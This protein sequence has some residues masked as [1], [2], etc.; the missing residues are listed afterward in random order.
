MICKLDS[1][2]KEKEKEKE[3][4]INYVICKFYLILCKSMEKITRF[5]LTMWYV[6]S[7]WQYVAFPSKSSFILTMWYVNIV[8][9]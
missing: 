1:G 3:F 2:E 5:I 4:Y 7:I 6:N 9:K 8:T